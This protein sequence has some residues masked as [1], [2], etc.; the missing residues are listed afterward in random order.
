MADA[1]QVTEFKDTDY[2]E[3]EEEGEKQCITLRHCLCSVGSYNSPGGERELTS[4]HIAR[5]NPP[6][7]LSSAVEGQVQGDIVMV[8]CTS[9]ARKTECVANSAPPP[10]PSL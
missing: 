6:P 9:T 8:R 10:P 5:R 4:L 1:D 2:E 3:V 7:S